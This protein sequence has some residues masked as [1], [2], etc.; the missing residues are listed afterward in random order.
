MKRYWSLLCSLFLRFNESR[1][2]IE[3]LFNLLR[4]AASALCGLLVVG[5]TEVVKKTPHE[6]HVDTGELG[7]LMP[8][9]RHWL[10]LISAREHCS[11]LAKEATLEDLKDGVV[12]Y[13][14]VNPK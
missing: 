8:G 14:C 13:R 2:L 12:I 11:S 3:Q 5:C 9:S 1:N 6:V 4:I 7:Q 10:A